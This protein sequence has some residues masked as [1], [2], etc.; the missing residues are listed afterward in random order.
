MKDSSCVCF[1]LTDPLVLLKLRLG[2]SKYITLNLDLEE[3]KTS[4]MK[5]FSCVCFSLTDP[6]VPTEIGLSPPASLNWD[7]HD[8]IREEG[9]QSNKRTDTLKKSF[10]LFFEVYLMQEGL[11]VKQLK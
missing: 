9:E 6:L 1:P 8:N 7:Q 2:P 4:L 3:E 11:E 10:F 5:D